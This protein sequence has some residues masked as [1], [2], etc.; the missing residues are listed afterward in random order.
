[1]I[2]GEIYAKISRNSPDDADSD[3]PCGRC[4]FDETH[5]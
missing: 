5:S 1:M 3:E 2:D 4:P